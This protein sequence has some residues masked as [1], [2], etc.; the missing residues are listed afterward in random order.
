MK[1][2]NTFPD[3][4]EVEDGGQTML[5]SDFCRDARIKAGMSQSKL[6]TLSGLGHPTVNNYESGR[7]QSLKSMLLA[8]LTLGY[9]I[10]L[11]EPAGVV[12]RGRR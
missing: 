12:S 10:E 4:W 1:L 3:G 5:L 2:V 11:K 7:Y 9:E 6:N 8:L